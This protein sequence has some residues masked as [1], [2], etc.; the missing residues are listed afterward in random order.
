[1]HG[2]CSID[3]AHILQK[4]S[5]TMKSRLTKLWGE[6]RGATVALRSVSDDVLLDRLTLTRALQATVAGLQVLAF[7]NR[8]A[9]GSFWPLSIIIAAACRSTLSSTYSVAARCVFNHLGVC[10]CA[11]S[12]DR[13]MRLAKRGLV[14]S[15]RTEVG[16]V[17]PQVDCVQIRVSG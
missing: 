14:L 7:I 8:T 9:S 17:F 5:Q 10:T 3:P 16:T 4:L 13:L 2:R 1:M 15:F 6:S 11:S 12:V